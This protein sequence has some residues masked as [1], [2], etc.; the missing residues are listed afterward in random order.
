MRL[1]TSCSGRPGIPHGRVVRWPSISSAIQGISDFSCRAPQAVLN[2]N[3]SECGVL[4]NPDGAMGTM[5]IVQ[6]SIIEYLSMIG[7]PLGTEGQTDMHCSTPRT[8]TSIL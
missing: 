4:G 1:W 6:A 3:T 8:T 2:L 5:Y 7:T